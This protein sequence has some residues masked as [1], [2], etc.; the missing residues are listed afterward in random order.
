MQ[1]AFSSNNGCCL[2]T[3]RNGTEERHTNEILVNVYNTNSPAKHKTME[4][5]NYNNMDSLKILSF[6]VRS[7]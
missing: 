4:G 2:P 3:G 7:C 6:K 1:G 5:R